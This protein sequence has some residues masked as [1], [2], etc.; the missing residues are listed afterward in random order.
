MVVRCK[1]ISGLRGVGVHRVLMSESS[2]AAGTGAYGICCRSNAF[3]A[4][5]YEDFLPQYN[6]IRQNHNNMKNG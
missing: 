3:L 1:V 4:P 2:H 5:G 6:S